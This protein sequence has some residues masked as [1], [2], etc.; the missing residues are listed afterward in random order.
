M[1]IGISLPVTQHYSNPSVRRL[2]GR[3]QEVGGRRQEAVPMKKFFSPPCMKVPLDPSPRPRVSASLSSQEV[4]GKKGCFV[5]FLTFASTAFH[6]C[7]FPFYNWIYSL[8]LYRSI[9]S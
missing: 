9:A 3:R 5:D 2:R 8:L 7:L 4:E 6:K 1:I